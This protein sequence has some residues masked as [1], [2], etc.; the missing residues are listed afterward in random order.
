MLNEFF[1]TKIQINV[2]RLG[3]NAILACL[4]EMGLGGDMQ[5]ITPALKRYVN[6]NFRVVEFTFGHYRA[7]MAT[8]FLKRL[9][10]VF[11]PNFLTIQVNT[12][13]AFNSEMELY[14]H[15][16]QNMDWFYAFSDDHRVWC[17]GEASIAKLKALRLSLS[18]SYEGKLKA[19]AL[20]AKYAK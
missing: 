8:S 14:E 19:D 3:S 9:G 10:E 15:L 20:W 2:P 4:K 12:T 7:S 13:P 1:N 17:A 6:G 16:L 5:E 18:K 11:H